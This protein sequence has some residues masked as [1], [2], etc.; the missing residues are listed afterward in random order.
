MR[1]SFSIFKKHLSAFSP[2]ETGRFYLVCATQERD[3]TFFNSFPM[4]EKVFA[5]SLPF[6]LRYFSQLRRVFLALLPAAIWKET[7]DQD[8]HILI[9]IASVNE[10]CIAFRHW[11]KSLLRDRSRLEYIRESAG[12]F[13]FKVHVKSAIGPPACDLKKKNVTHT[14]NCI[15]CPCVIGRHNVFASTFQM[16]SIIFTWENIAN[17]LNSKKK[18]T[19][20]YM[21]MAHYQVSKE[22]CT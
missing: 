13:D 3:F 11:L 10:K 5:E 9:F 7:P 18:V 21:S 4:K 20:L 17:V 8:S 1:D 19:L 16:P 2:L 15:K 6:F 12:D 14:T 22:K